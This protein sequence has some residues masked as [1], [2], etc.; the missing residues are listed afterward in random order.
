LRWFNYDFDVKFVKS[1]SCSMTSHFH[2]VVSYKLTF[3]AREIYTYAQRS[4]LAD[5]D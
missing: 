3:C 1:T 5:G 4:D 2:V